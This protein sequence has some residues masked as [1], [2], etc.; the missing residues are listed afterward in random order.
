MDNLEEKL[1]AYIKEL[2]VAISVLSQLK[3]IGLESMDVQL[4][5]CERLNIESMQPI[6]L[7]K[8]KISSDQMIELLKDY[9][10]SKPETIG[11]VELEE[12]ILPAGIPKLLTEQTIKVKGEIWIVHKNDVDP[13]PSAPHAHNYESGVSLHLG[14]G[15]IFRKRASK[16]FVTCKNLKL[17]RAEITNH[18]LPSLDE[19]CK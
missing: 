17:V 2:H 1:I 11:T 19:R 8:N 7:L 9:N 13:F 16:G 3:G 14:T 4:A 10:F 6:E 15:E 5:L 12:S 18:E